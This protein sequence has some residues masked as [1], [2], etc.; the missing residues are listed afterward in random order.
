[1]LNDLK[2]FHVYPQVDTFLRVNTNL[3]SSF[4]EGFVLLIITMSIIRTRVKTKT[5][6]PG[7]IV[8]V[9]LIRYSFVRF[10]LEYLRADSQ[11][12]FHGLFTVSQRF[13][14]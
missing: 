11:L 4:F 2:I 13:F 12:E 9:F 5:P 7:K 3:L 14:L 6:Q 10:M 8:A 1:M